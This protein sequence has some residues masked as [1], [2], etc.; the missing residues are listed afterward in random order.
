ML[1]SRKRALNLDSN[2]GF[3]PSMLVLLLGLRSLSLGRIT[4]SPYVHG[5][6]V[7]STLL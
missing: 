3:L 4:V 1:N 7:M 5:C 2:L 6:S